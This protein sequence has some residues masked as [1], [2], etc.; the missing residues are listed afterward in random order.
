VSGPAPDQPAGEAPVASQP[1]D[2]PERAKAALVA[3]AQY[4]SGREPSSPA[5]LLVTQAHYLVGRPFAEIVEMLFPAFSD[6]ARF[7]FGQGQMFKLGLQRVVSQAR[8][9][10]VADMAGEGGDG[11][12]EPWPVPGTRGAALTL[13]GDVATWFRSAQ[14]SSPIPLI[15]DRARTM[16]EKDF[17]SLA[18]DLLPPEALGGPP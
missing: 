15:L 3:V 10:S 17:L 7:Q 9:S 14:P 2:G 6:D 5:L 1:I 13:L 4:F 11:A 8:S 18:R 12:V 16:A